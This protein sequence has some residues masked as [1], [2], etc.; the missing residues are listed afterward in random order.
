MLVVI[1]SNT[2]WKSVANELGR[3]ANIIGNQVRVTNTIKFI[4]KEELT[5]GFTVTYANFMCDYRP[6][7][8]EP[9]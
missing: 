8:S 9:F 1:N 7:K 6:L 5:Q 2:W 3:L 4:Q